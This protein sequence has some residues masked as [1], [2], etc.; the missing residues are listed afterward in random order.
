M[1]VLGDI[2]WES[3][4]GRL[5]IRTAKEVLDGLTV[6]YVPVIGDDD[7]LFG[8]CGLDFIETF[9][10]VHQSLA[11][12]ASDP[13]SGFADWRRGPTKVLSPY[14]PAYYDYFLNFAFEYRGV[15]FICADFCSRDGS[16][17]IFK[18]QDDDTDLHDHEGGTWPWFTRCLAECPKDKKEN[19]VLMAHN[20]LVTLRT[21]GIL[22]TVADGLTLDNAEFDKL[23]V[24]LNDPNC[25]YADHVQAI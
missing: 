8:R 2:G 22:K 6:P 20:P 24:F 15:Q 25:N 13:G 17:T 11:E 5:N 7:I 16:R 23:S 12:L 3:N 10:P 21:W 19:I 14:R 9:E 18:T 1:F 4:D